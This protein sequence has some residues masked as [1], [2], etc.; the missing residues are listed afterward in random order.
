V[1]GGEDQRSNPCGGIG[2]CSGL[3]QGAACEFGAA[4]LIFRMSRHVDR[5]VEPERRLYLVRVQG[6]WGTPIELAEAI[7]EM[8]YGV[9]GSGR[10]VVCLGDLAEDR[11]PI[12]LGAKPVPE[13]GPA[14]RI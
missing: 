3:D 14:V 2:G 8:L 13:T 7:L 4:F 10:L 9:V 1:T 11:L 5:I 12:A 6:D